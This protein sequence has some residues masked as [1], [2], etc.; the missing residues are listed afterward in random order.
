MDRDK[1]I[2]IEPFNVLKTIAKIKKNRNK[3]FVRRPLL[4]EPICS[5]RFKQHNSFMLYCYLQ[6][7]DIY[8]DFDN[9][10]NG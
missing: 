3:K 2:N 5:I 9:F 8:S 10:D 7:E 4:I 1:L 6:I